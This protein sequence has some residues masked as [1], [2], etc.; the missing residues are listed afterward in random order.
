MDSS[1]SQQSYLSLYAQYINSTPNIY[2]LRFR[3]KKTNIQ[4]LSAHSEPENQEPSNIYS[5]PKQVAGCIELPTIQEQVDLENDT[6]SN[7]SA[8]IYQQGF[9]SICEKPIKAQSN[10]NEVNRLIQ[11]IQIHGKAYSLIALEL[12]MPVQLIQRQIYNLFKQ[13]EETA[14]SDKEWIELTQSLN[15]WDLNPFSFYHSINQDQIN[16][17]NSFK[18]AFKVTKNQKFSAQYCCRKFG[19]DARLVNTL[20]RQACKI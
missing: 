19:V 14:V 12:N 11:A 17:L 13:I 5:L 3:S 15:T 7:F 18:A 1:S 4:K 10:Q 6:E 16:I 2:G 9:D 20:V 8:I